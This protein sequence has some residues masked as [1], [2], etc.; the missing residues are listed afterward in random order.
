MRW[1]CLSVRFNILQ[2]GSLEMSIYIVLYHDCLNWN[3]K[4]QWSIQ[5]DRS[6]SLCYYE[7]SIYLYTQIN[8]DI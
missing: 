3:E 4:K 1:E 2:I 7:V 8:G 5:L 6:F